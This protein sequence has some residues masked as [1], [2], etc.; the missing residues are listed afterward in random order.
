MTCC[1]RPMARQGD[2]WVCRQ[3]SAWYIPGLIARRRR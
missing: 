1:G 3:C 2:K